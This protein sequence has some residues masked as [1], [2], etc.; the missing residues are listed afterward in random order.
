MTAR[1]GSPGTVA[2]LGARLAA[3]EARLVGAE[4]R[5]TARWAAAAAALAASAA[6]V[7]IAAGA[8]LVAAVVLG[9]AT[10]MPAWLAALITGTGLLVLAGFLAISAWGV[11]GPDRG[12]PDGEGLAI[13]ELGLALGTRVAI[14]GFFL[15]AL[16]LMGGITQLPV[17]ML[18]AVALL[19]VEWPLGWLVHGRHTAAHAAARQPRSEP[20]P[21][22]SYR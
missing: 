22:R 14:E 12:R 20:A 2:R 13:I 10:A 17:L 15:V 21:A 6:V 16:V 7:G 9:L 1:G 4:L 3:A 18:V 19:A 5:R 11:W 8:C